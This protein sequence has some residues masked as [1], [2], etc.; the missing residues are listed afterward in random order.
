MDL[1]FDPAVDLDVSGRHALFARTAAGAWIVRDLGSTNGTFVNGNRIAGDVELSPSD[2]IMF[3]D[4][5]PTVEFRAGPSSALAASSGSSPRSSESPATLAV[6]L[7]PRL[8]RPP[9]GNPRRR[10]VATLSIVLLSAVAAVAVF[11]ARSRTAILEDERVLLQQRIDSLTVAGQQSIQSLQSEV[12]ELSDALR[13]SRDA[14]QAATSRLEQAQRR[15][16]AAEVAAIRDQLD[17]ATAIQ[18]QREAAAGLDFLAIQRI[19]RP[20]VA[21]IYVEGENGAVSTGTAF[22]VRPDATLVTSR[23]V[24]TGEGGTERP[25]RIAI[26]FSDSDQVWPARILRIS[27]D[28]D[29][30]VVKVDN[31]LGSV[32]T[33]GT[34]NLRPDT[35]SAGSVVASIGFPVGRGLSAAATYD[36]G[37]IVEP[38]LS[39]GIIG[40]VSSD[41]IEIQ[42][43]GSA[44]ASGSPVFDAAGSVIAVLFGGLTASTHPTLVGVP[45]TAVAALLNRLP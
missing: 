38:L 21:I 6:P 23:H 7:D 19:N 32:P 11:S 9:G 44:G 13:E 43:Y 34:L 26:Q 27:E 33:I 45:S 12:A 31:I 29:L 14:V 24:L 39:A 36:R 28:S 41:R 5:G 25:R 22:A 3:G 18:G 16:D 17:S 10:L 30:G 15:G 2:R 35:I 4:S 40:S 1:R 8:H 42:G 20:A 37:G